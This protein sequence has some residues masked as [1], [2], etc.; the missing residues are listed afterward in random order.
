MQ[1]LEWGMEYHAEGAHPP[2]L[3]GALELLRRSD[4]PVTG[5]VEHFRNFLVVRSDVSVVGVAG[6]EPCGDDG[7][8]RSVAVE[9]AYRGSGVGRALVDGVF[10]LARRLELRS[11]Y[12]LTTTARDYFQRQGFA[13]CPRDE[14]PPAIRETWEFRSGCPSSSAFMRR[15]V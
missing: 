2:D 15:S 6:L 3:P 9:P 7:L 5:V 8:L 12:L 11:L 1:S 10:G 14:A 4:L 13:D